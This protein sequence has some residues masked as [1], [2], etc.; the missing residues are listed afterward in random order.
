MFCCLRAV[1]RT[2]TAVQGDGSMI[3]NRHYIARNYYRVALRYAF[4]FEF[5]RFDTAKRR[6][7]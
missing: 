3:S 7:T 5:D 4:T 6:V 2:T 1:T